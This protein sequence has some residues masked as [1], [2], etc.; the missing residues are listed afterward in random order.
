MKRN[1][2]QKPPANIPQE[3]PGPTMAEVSRQIA[4]LQ[5]SLRNDHIQFPEVASCSFCGQLSTDAEPLICTPKDMEYEAFICEP[6]TRICVELF[7]KQRE[8][9]PAEASK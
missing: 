3:P 6:C 4:D 8:A 1:A 5:A 9:E 2:P 7:K